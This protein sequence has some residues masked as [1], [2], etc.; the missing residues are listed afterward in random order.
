MY[1]HLRGIEKV[2][3]IHLRI[4]PTVS[5]EDLHRQRI[6]GPR[7]IRQGTDTVVDVGLEDNV[8]GLCLGIGES[9]RLPARLQDPLA[10][11]QE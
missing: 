9:N 6:G 4:V 3:F 5:S 2:V 10:A 1:D 7:I 8:L 11:V